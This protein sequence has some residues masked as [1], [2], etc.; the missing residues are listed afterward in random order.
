MNRQLKQLK[1]QEWQGFLKTKQW[2]EK[3][4]TSAS[5]T[6]VA[7]RQ[8]LITEIVLSCTT[9]MTVQV[10]S[11]STVKWEFDMVAGELAHLEMSGCPVRCEV[12]EAAT[13]AITSGTGKINIS[14]VTI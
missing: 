13:V 12:G 5:K 14:G 1:D 6:G 11:A 8:H 2:H 3:H 7:S 10:K 4:A 9:N